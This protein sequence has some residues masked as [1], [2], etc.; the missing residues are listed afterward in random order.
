MN[1]CRVCGNTHENR[2]HTFQEKFF[3]LGDEFEY[4]ECG[5]CGSLSIVTVPEN[6]ERYYPESYYAYTVQPYNRFSGYLKGVRDRYYLNGAGVIGRLLSCQRRE[7][8]NY[9]EWLRNLALPFGSSIL[10][11]GCGSGTL[12]INLQD[13][14][15]QATG[16]DAYISK[17]VTY[18]NGVRV[19][20]QSLQETDGRYDCIMLHHCLEH[21]PA[22]RE[23]LMHVHRLLE[24]GGKALVRIPVAGNYAWRTYGRNWFQLDAPRHF[25]I[26]SERGLCSMAGDM[27]YKVRK[28]I[29]DS[30]ASQFWASEQYV[31]GIA[32]T[33]QRSYA[34]HAERSLF[35]PQQIAEYSKRAAQLNSNA[36][37]DQAAYYFEK[38]A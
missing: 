6:V 19:L 10:D 35:T 1:A 4:T 17:P 3:G 20:K 22:P 26:L 15:F 38:A 18:A 37:G 9:I 16:I 7:A 8:P 13:A 2:L 21:M 28:I 29:Y 12:I 32:L 34:V 36:D 25:V 33:D 24:P 27:G 23:A 11:V 14:G 31:K 30:T 5:A